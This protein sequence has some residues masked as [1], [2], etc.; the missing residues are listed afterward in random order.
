MEDDKYSLEL[1]VAVRVVHMACLL[2]QKVQ[3]GLLFTSTTEQFKSKDDNSP[4]TVAGIFR[5]FFL[6]KRKLFSFFLMLFD[7][8]HLN[9][10][11]IVIL[12]FFMEYEALHC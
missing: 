9:Y 8:K 6:W 11:I 5:F 1:N 2:C 10:A 7:G 4:V 12:F 3:K